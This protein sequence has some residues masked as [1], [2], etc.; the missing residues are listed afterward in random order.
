[1]F[2]GAGLSAGP[3]NTSSGAGGGT[4]LGGIRFGDLNT[5]GSTAQLAVIAVAA[6]ALGFLLGRA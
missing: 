6:F 2:G 5:G 1:M 3:S 4:L